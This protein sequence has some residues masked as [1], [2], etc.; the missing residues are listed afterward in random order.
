MG[1]RQKSREA[2]TER[3]VVRVYYVKMPESREVLEWKLAGAVVE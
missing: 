2:E 3:V 1:G